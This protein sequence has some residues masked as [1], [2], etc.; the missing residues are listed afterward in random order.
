[1]TFS[2]WENF[3][4][5]LQWAKMERSGLKKV[6]GS[7]H[8][9]G[10][11]FFGAGFGEGAYYWVEKKMIGSNFSPKRG[12]HSWPLSHRMFSLPLTKNLQMGPVAGETRG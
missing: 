10:A 8:F 9:D 7:V 1:M 4:F 11:E 2:A 12:G 6:K 5:E 3:V